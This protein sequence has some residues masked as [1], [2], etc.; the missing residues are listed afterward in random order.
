MGQPRAGWG[1]EAP[2]RFCF[3]VIGTR[4]RELTE[5]PAAR[6]LQKNNKLVWDET[7]RILDD[8]FENVW[9]TEASID[10]DNITELTVPVRPPSSPP[11]PCMSVWQPLSCT[12]VHAR[13]PPHAKCECN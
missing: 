13:P 7:V 6:D 9:G 10:V 1:S 3:W 8:L 5:I 2:L 4:S 12:H 11:S